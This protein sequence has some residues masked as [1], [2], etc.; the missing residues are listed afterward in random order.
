M[1]GTL[2]FP[3]AQ[4]YLSFASTDPS[5]SGIN[6]TKTGIT[7][8]LSTLVAAA[9]K[10][11]THKKKSSP[12]SKNFPYLQAHESKQQ[13]DNLNTGQNT[14]SSIHHSV[15]LVSRKHHKGPYFHLLYSSPEE[16]LIRKQLIFQPCNYPILLQKPPA[17]KNTICTRQHLLHH[18]CPLLLHLFIAKLINVLVCHIL[19]LI[20]TLQP[21]F[22]QKS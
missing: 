1:I 10:T 18:P 11:T 6:A 20:S 17:T 4:S 3:N 19:V 16:R 7:T 5:F 2:D 12:T 9:G 15:G 14:G 22:I 21:C 8:P 13:Q